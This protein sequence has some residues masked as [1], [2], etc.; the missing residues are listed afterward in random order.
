MEMIGAV[1]VVITL[2]NYFIKRNELKFEKKV[3]YKLYKAVIISIILN[4]TEETRNNLADCQNKLLLVSS[5]NI[6]DKLMKFHDYI[7]PPYINFSLDYHDKLLTDLM[8]AMRKGLFSNR[9]VNC[10]DPTI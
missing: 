1:T 2:T 9:K 5:A 3:L 10:N 8:M 7:K 4:Y 6:V